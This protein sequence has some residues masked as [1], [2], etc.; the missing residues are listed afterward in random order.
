MHEYP[1]ETGRQKWAVECRF[2]DQK[3]IPDP[4]VT[5][6]FVRWLYTAM[7]RFTDEV[8]LINFSPPFFDQWLALTNH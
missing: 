2:V 5:H 6:E 3:Y 8:Y 1:I 7:T 4:T